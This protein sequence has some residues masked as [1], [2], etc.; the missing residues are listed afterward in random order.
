MIFVST[1]PAPW[2]FEVLGCIFAM[3]SHTAGFFE[4]GADP[5]KAFE[6][7]KN[8]LIDRCL[9]L[10]GDGVTNCQFEY[11]VCLSEGIFGKKQC[12]ELFAYGTV[13][14]KA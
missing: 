9:A 3:D 12:V 2:P 13:V 5:N 8:N 6:K 14:R 1:G 7:V 10:N 11:R 4:F